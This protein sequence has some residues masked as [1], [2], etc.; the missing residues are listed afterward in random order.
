V[1]VFEFLAVTKYSLFILENSAKAVRVCR[2]VLDPCDYY[3]ISFGL[4]G[5]SIL[6][7]SA[8]SEKQGAAFGGRAWQ[9]AA[10]IPLYR[11]CSA[12]SFNFLGELTVFFRSL[13]T[14]CHAVRGMLGG[15]LE[16]Q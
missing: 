14:L 2:S 12:C 11:R 6:L 16:G 8:L 7:I 1:G 10:Q 3:G 9:N 13:G 5:F 15:L 4:F